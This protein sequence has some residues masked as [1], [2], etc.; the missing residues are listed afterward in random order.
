IACTVIFGVLFA[1]RKKLRLPGQMAGLYLICNG[2]ERFSIEKIRVNT[3]YDGL[4]FQP[5]QAELISCGLIVFGAVLMYLASQNRF[6][7]K[8]A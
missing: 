4:P 8:P 7:K 1:V 5:T 6:S 2:L 3:K